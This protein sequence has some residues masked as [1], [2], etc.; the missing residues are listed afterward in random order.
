MNNSLPFNKYAFLTTHNAF[1]IEGEPSHTGVPRFTVNNQEHSITQQL[2]NGVRAL[3]LDTY[4]FDG[5]VWLCHSFKGQCHDVTAFEPA[6]DTLKEIEAF[7]SAN[8]NEIVTIILEDYV[9]SPNGLTKVFSD[10]GLKKYWFPL[11]SMP[12]NGENWPLVSDLVA[13][14]QRLVVFTSKKG[15][16]QS[17]GIAYQWNYMVENQSAFVSFLLISHGYCIMCEHLSLNERRSTAALACV[18]YLTLV[19]YKASVPYFTVLLLLN[20]FISFYVIFH[21]ISQNLLVLREQLSIIENEDVRA[22]HDAVYKKYIM[23]K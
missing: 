2:N 21:H 1:A 6:I 8:T 7:L 13:K 4:D 9:E 14:N 20:Y 17:E 16:E 19:G 23:F 22:M 10:A 3:M 15:K 18:F 11:A 5:D 12:K